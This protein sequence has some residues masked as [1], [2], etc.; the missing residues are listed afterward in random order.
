MGRLK[1]AE[2]LLHI[3]IHA[4]GYTMYTIVYDSASF[5]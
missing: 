3:M 5:G 4:T 1:I 2:L